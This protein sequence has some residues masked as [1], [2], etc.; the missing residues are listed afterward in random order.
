MISIDDPRLDRVIEQLDR[1]FLPFVIVFFVADAIMTYPFAATFMGWLIQVLVVAVLIFPIS[2]GF[3]YLCFQAVWKLALSK[4]GLRTFC[5]I[6]L[7]I[8]GLF[9]VGYLLGFFLWSKE[10]GTGLY[11]MVIPLGFTGAT[12]RFWNRYLSP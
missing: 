8:F 11:G 9:L 2:Y 3:G 10:Y 4:S 12:L 7:G 5:M 6:L 1:W